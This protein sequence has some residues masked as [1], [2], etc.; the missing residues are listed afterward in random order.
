[1]WI[2]KWKKTFPLGNKPPV[3]AF[4]FPSAGARLILLFSF[5][6][7]V[8]SSLFLLQLLSGLM[9][10]WSLKGKRVVGDFRSFLNVSVCRLSVWSD[11]RSLKGSVLCAVPAAG[12][13]VLS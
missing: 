6:F 5:L 3:S 1:M 2:L 4:C 8:A 13:H 11:Y 7:L 12:G 10:R 9:F